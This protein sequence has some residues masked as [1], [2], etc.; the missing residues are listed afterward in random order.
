VLAGGAIA[1]FLIPVRP[2]EVGIFKHLQARPVVGDKLDIHHVPQ[3][4]PVGQVIEGYDYV[5]APAIRRV[6][7]RGAS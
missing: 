5:N 2:Y 4:N 3:G 7:V 6:A 1:G